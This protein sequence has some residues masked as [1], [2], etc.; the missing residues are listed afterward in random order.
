MIAVYDLDLRILCQLNDEELK[1]LVIGLFEDLGTRV[2][3]VN[4]D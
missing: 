3:H 2:L 4:R 1:K